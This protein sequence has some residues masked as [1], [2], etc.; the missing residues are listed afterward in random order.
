MKSPLSQEK[1]NYKP[2]LSNNPNSIV[3][4]ISVIA[5]LLVGLTGDFMT[6]WGYAEVFIVSQ[7]RINAP[8][9]HTYVIH[10]LYFLIWVGS[11]V[12]NLSFN[13]YNKLFGYKEIIAITLVMWGS[14]MIFLSECFTL[15]NLAIMLF[16]NGLQEGVRT[17]ILGF[18]LVDMFPNHMSLAIAFSTMGSP[19][20]IIYYSKLTEFVVNPDNASPTIHIKEGQN[21]M[22]YFGSI[23][24]KRVLTLF[25][26]SGCIAIGTGILV[27]I[28]CM[29]PVGIENNT[30]KKIRSCLNGKKKFECDEEM[31]GLINDCLPESIENK[32]D[33]K[34][35]IM[36]SLEPEPK[37]DRK[38][39]KQNSSNDTVSVNLCQNNC[40]RQPIDAN[41]TETEANCPEYLKTMH[42]WFLF[43]SISYS[44]SAAYFFQANLKNF[45]LKHFSDQIINSSSY[46]ACAFSIIGRISTGIV[47]DKFGPYIVLIMS[48]ILGTVI[49]FLFYFYSAH[50][51]MFYLNTALIFQVHGG[52]NVQ[53]NVVV[54]N[55][56][57]K[58]NA[59][60]TQWVMNM[61]RQIGGCL[62]LL[63]NT[64]FLEFMGFEILFMLMILSNLAIISKIM[65]Y[66]FQQVR[67]RNIDIQRERDNSKNLADKKSKNYGYDKKFKIQQ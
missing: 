19:L 60:K 23:V 66:M 61:S 1:K 64:V 16:L 40:L 58:I 45:Y 59:F 17:M 18:L 50:L 22:S 37:S 52:Q 67:K 57:G 47:V 6:M 51:S 13:I 35:Q 41:D 63:W 9:L 28:F 27:K 39:S 44:L 20:G 12:S 49:I 48:N 36:E 53:I 8:H 25:F 43:A 11:A 5:I 14:Y 34:D 21:T 29:N 4:I 38:G 56:Y 15:P 54:M 32:F 42:F 33:I 31:N 2:T 26:I 10:I 24:S 7:A 65:L 46:V 55:L 3:K 30:Q 62:L